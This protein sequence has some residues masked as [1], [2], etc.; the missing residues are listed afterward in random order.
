MDEERWA[1]LPIADQMAN[2]GAEVGRAFAALRRHDQE[3]LEG[4]LRRGLDLFDLTAN[5]WARRKSPRTKEILRARSLFVEAITT[6]RD[7]PQLERY[8]MQF[9]AMARLRAR[10]GS[11][12]TYGP[13]SEHLAG[14]S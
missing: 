11:D 8:F 6:G 13:R 12:E 2:I 1:R 5:V 4:A 3:R 14:R 7:D 10:A 9:A